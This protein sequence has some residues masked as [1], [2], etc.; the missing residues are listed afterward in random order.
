MLHVV[1][2]GLPT[3]PASREIPNESAAAA[4]Q[5]RRRDINSNNKNNPPIII[6]KSPDTVPVDFLEKMLSSRNETATE[7]EPEEIPLESKS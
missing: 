3:T 7:Q 4:G 6:P 1:A 2:N 5:R